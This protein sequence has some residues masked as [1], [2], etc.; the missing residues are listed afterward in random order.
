MLK[1][2]CESLH[3]RTNVLGKNVSS[4]VGGLGAVD[5]FGIW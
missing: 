4:S 2:M 5:G 3:L 1:D